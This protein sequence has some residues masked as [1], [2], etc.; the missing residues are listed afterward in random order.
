MNIAQF[1]ERRSVRLLAWALLILIPGEPVMAGL[2]QD[3]DPWDRKLK[4]AETKFYSGEFDSSIAILED[5]LKRADFPVTKKK[6]AY[7]LL[8]QNY[9]AKSYQ[10][11]ARAAIKK[12]LELVPNYVPPT[13]ATEYAAEVEKVRQSMAGV[14]Q[15]EKWYEKTWVWIVGG[16]VVVG[17]VALVLLSGK[18]EE[19]KPELPGP[20]ARP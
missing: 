9:L 11:Q 1:F 18:K 2:L 19:A 16:A 7:E 3:Q 14:P 12:L 20:P 6:M 13:D 15:E 17:A 8:A 4:E 10:E 5:V